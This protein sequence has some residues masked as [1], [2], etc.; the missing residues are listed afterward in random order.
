M[1]IEGHELE[2]LAGFD[3]DRYRPRLFCIEA[4]EALADRIYEYLRGH[5]YARVDRYLPFDQRNW[6]F[7]P[8]AR[9]RAPAKASPQMG[10][11]PAER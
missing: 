7:A 2:A 3:I 5:G 1:D 10:T 6:Y 8:E 11:P 4:Q 9:V